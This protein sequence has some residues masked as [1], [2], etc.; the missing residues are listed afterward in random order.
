MPKT[1]IKPGSRSSSPIQ[2]SAFSSS[3]TTALSSSGSATPA[4][5]NGNHEIKLDKVKITPYSESK[6][7]EST[8][9]E[10][11]LLLQQVWRDKALDIIKYL[12]DVTY[13]SHA[14][15]SP[16]QI[17]ADKLIYYIL[18]AGS[19]RDSFARN[20]IIAAQSKTAQPHIPDNEGLLL[21]NHFD[22][23]FVSKDST[24]PVSLLLNENSMLFSRKTMKKP[25]TILL[26][27]TW[28]C[29]ALLNL[30]NVS[31]TILGSLPW[32]T[33]F[34]PNTLKRETVLTFQN[35]ASNLS[36]KLKPQY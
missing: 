7:W 24:Q 12:T 14:M 31:Q 4:A 34:V 15:G 36:G 17:K 26:V 8:A 29:P 5:T 3:G 19:V 25:A 35:P 30:E 22:H 1:P 9:F 6:D 16:A 32:Q 33:D 2:A 18:S 20:T 21:Y 28:L 11:K 13:A 23:I 27:W 10:L